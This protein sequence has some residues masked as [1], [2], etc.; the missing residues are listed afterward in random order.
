MS[1]NEINMATLDDRHITFFCDDCHRV[2]EATDKEG[3][4]L[5]CPECGKL[6]RIIIETENPGE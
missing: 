1:K 2:M 3:F 6:A 4:H 5:E